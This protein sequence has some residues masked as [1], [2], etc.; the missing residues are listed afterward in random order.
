MRLTKIR[1]LAVPGGLVGGPFGSN[2]VSADYAPEGVPVIRGENLGNGKWVAGGFVY[3]SREKASGDL[4]RN[5][6]APGDLVFTQR[7]TLGQVA[8][9]PEGEHDAYVVSQSQMRLRADPELADGDFLYY[10]CSSPT[11]NQHVLDRAITTGVPHINLAILGSLEVPIPS[12]AQQQAIA[13]VLGALDDKIAANRKVVEAADA[14][15]RQRYHDMLGEVR[16]GLSALANFVNGRAYTKGAS[17]TGRVVIRIA[18]LNSGIGGS[19]VY[20]DIDDVPEDNLA[21][22]GDLLFAWSGSLMA[23]RWY[24]PEGIVNQHIF[25]VLPKANWPMWLVSCALDRKLEDFRAIAADKATTMG[26]I[27][28]RHLDEL[29][30]VPTREQI[31]AADEMMSALWDRALVA[32]VESLHLAQLR[33][34]LLPHLMSGRLSVRQAETLVDEVL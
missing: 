27:Q 5:W 14:V 2:L 4:A 16:E 32:E 12:I 6:A 1:E 31:A 18:E 8:V 21:R 11:F 29:V 7:G 22:P 10:A 19:T 34:T 28:R 9:V 24:R 30:G 17:G 23:H 20:N 26:H 33:D 3:V 15:R 25:K 13:D